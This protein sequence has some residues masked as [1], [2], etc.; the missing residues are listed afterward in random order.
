M[1][2]NPSELNIFMDVEFYD[3]WQSWAFMNTLQRTELLSQNPTPVSPYA[4]LASVLSQTYYLEALRIRIAESHGPRSAWN[5][6]SRSRAI[7]APFGL[8]FENSF[9]E[10]GS[11]RVELSLADIRLSRLKRI[12]LDGFDDIEPLLALTP[13]LEVLRMSLSTGYPQSAILD[14]IEAIVRTPKLRELTFPPGALHLP[15]L[16]AATARVDPRP[17]NIIDVIGRRLPDL[18]VLDLRTYWHG[19]DVHFVHSIEYLN[20]DVS[21]D[22]STKLT[23]CSLFPFTSGFTGFVAVSAKCAHPCATYLSND[24]R[25]IDHAAVA[26]ARYKPGQ[27]F[28]H[29]SRTQESHTEHRES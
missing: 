7:A 1:F 12:E 29:A 22:I 26:C 6:F 4:L 28:S 19:D 11:F 2:N 9:E 15:G 24:R 5:K 23:R 13:N 14:L 17:P 27:H 8:G 3:S 18:E 16:D 10:V 25:R 20:Q 21:N